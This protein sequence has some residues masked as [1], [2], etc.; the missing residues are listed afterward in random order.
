MSNHEDYENLPAPERR[1]FLGILS[2][3]IT[4]GIGAVMAV[5]IG[6]YSFSPIFE[7]AASETEWSDLGPISS[8][9]EGKLIKKTVT[10]AQD[11]GWGKFEAQRSVWVVRKGESVK[12][13][14][15]VCPHLGCSVNNQEDKFVCACHGSYWDSDGKTTAGPTPRELDLLEHRVEDEKLKI[16]YQYFKQGVSNKEVLS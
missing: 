7:T 9:E 13:F 10:V 8:L 15:G 16:R 2:G 1:S 12:V 5:T 3:L 6:R 4:A 11:A 14:S